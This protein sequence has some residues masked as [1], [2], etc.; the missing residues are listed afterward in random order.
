MSLYVMQQVVGWDVTI[1]KDRYEDWRQLGKELNGWCKKWVFQE[2]KGAGGY[3]HWQVRL[4][5][6][7]RR[8]LASMKTELAQEGG[9]MY[10]VGGH[11]SITSS[12]VHLNNKFNY[13]MKKD[14]RVS[15][16][17]KDGDYEEPPV[18]TRQL[19]R[20]RECE[21]YPWQQQVIDW[22]M[23]E[24][25][26]FVR[27]V[28]DP[29]GNSGKSI[30]AEYLEYLG[31]AFE[32]PSMR[33]MEDIMQFCYSFKSQKAYLID[34]PRAMKKDKLG[35]FYAGLEC[36]KNG[37][38]YDKRYTGKKRRM[39]RPQVIVFTNVLPEFSFLSPDRWSVWTMQPDKSLVQTELPAMAPGLVAGFNPG[40]LKA[41]SGAAL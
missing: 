36:L 30:L 21:L 2:E 27:L 4:H 34:M 12:G 32:M 31:L 35:E 38:C 28:H 3:E 39:D 24:D 18:L 37:V 19:R 13:V 11:W 17:W 9:P 10:D 20:F 22:C 1:P 33:L 16:P 25:D 14:S 6:M 23:Q 26:R 7:G 29:P 41:P 5:L 40:A 15:G 8:T